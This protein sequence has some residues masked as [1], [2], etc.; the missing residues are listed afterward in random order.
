V[1]QL[2]P[3]FTWG[4]FLILIRTSGMLISAP[5]LSHKGIPSYTKVGFAVFFSL[6]L[7]PLQ[8]DVLPDPPVDFGAVANG[9]LRE[10]LF[11]LVLGLAMNLIFLGLQMS[12]QIM[13]VQLGFSLGGVLDPV[14]GNESNAL[15]Q[16]YAILVVLVFFTIN[17]H[18]VVIQTLAET[19][20]AVP[21]GT[22]D[23]LSMSSAGIAPLATGLTVTALRIA[24]P[25]VAALFLTDLGMGFV[26]RT[27][28]QVQ[29]MVVGAPIKVGVG[30]LVMAAALPATVHLMNGVISTSMAGSS[31]QLLGVR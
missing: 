24:M 10:V 5:L 20:R 19:V 31:Q 27:V 13:G 28:P 9:V 17:G 8:R 21:P 3:A 30:F 29:V 12:A 14:N 18:H 4:F 15:E 16:F 1:L 26:A 6:V 7:V 25:V 22:F 11:G 2:D 23:P